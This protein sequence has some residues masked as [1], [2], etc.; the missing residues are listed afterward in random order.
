MKNRSLT[1]SLAELSDVIKNYI[2]ARVRLFQV[3]LLNKISKA[4]TLIIT[5]VIIIMAICFVLLLLTMAFSFW[6]AE[7]Y[8]S[9]AEGLLLSTVF[10]IVFTLIIYWLRKPIVTNILIRKLAELF[11]DD[12]EE[13]LE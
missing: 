9:M 12:N 8:G 11:Y 1:D 4:G 7:N 13:D 5:A 6:Y 2:N 10:Y 3:L